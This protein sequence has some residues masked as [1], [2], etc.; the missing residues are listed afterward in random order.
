MAATEGS[1]EV[2]T[3]LLS[4]GYPIDILNAENQN[5][6]DIA[7][8]NEHTQVV[9]ALLENEN[10]RTL[11]QNERKKPKEK[12]GIFNIDWKKMIK[13]K[14]GTQVYNGENPQMYVMCKTKMWD[15][16]LQILDN[17][18]DE[19]NNNSYDFT[20]LDPP[21]QSLKKHPLMLVA[22][23]GVCSFLFFMKRVL[24]YW[25]FLRRKRSDSTLLY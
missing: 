12:R 21:F 2:V 6:L 13:S 14:K 5:A 20:V 22:Q 24:M 16:Y 3:L 7:L 4:K 17:S 19:E 25:E 9:R 1:H 18:F 8:E 23:S 10:W 15:S 11:I